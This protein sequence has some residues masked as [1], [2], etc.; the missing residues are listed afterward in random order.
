MSSRKLQ[1]RGSAT[2]SKRGRGGRRA[3]TASKQVDSKMQEDDKPEEG[4]L[5]GEE[6]VEEDEY[7]ALDDKN[8]LA[9]NEEVGSQ[10]YRLCSVTVFITLPSGDEEIIPKYQMR[11]KERPLCKLPVCAVNKSSENTVVHQQV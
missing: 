4:K 6:M 2:E 8:S 1:K 7:G 11:F 10:A 5:S 3:A 9:D